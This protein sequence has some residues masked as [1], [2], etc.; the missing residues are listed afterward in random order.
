MLM[1]G[2][3]EDMMPRMFNGVHPMSVAQDCLPIQLCTLSHFCIVNMAQTLELPYVTIFEDDA[4]PTKNCGRLL[5]DFL[6]ESEL[7]D[8]ADIII[9]GNLEFIHKYQ[10]YCNNVVFNN[11]YAMIRHKIWGA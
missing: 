2:F 7:P 11:H 5:G 4:V 6:Q 10:Y 3:S 8:D 9:W 1:T